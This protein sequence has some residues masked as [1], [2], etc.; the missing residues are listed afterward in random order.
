MKRADLANLVSSEVRIGSGGSC[1]EDHDTLMG[2]LE[3]NY[4]TKNNWRINQGIIEG[5]LIEEE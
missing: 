5:E 3:S 1:V 2:F 4:I